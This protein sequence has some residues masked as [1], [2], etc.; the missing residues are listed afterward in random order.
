MT[1][2][3]RT[4]C[5]RLELDAHQLNQ[6]TKCKHAIRYPVRTEV[7]R[8]EIEVCMQSASHKLLAA[9]VHIIRYVA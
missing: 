6:Y 3:H 1:H 8:L 5:A 4:N 9:A 7:Y 2:G